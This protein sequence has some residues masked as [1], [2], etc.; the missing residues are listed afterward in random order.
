MEVIIEP[1]THQRLMECRPT[2]DAALRLAALHEGCGCGATLLYEMNWDLPQ[3]D[4]LRQEVGS[5]TV[6]VDRESA[7][8]FDSTLQVEHL[9][10]AN[11]FSL[12]SANQ[13]YLSNTAL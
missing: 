2:T 6:V 3:P 4:D 9:P 8:Y 10:D 11:G 1:N 5:I 12:K 13:I 7:L